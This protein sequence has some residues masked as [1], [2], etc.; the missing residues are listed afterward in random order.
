MCSAVEE[1][2]LEQIQAGL[3]DAKFIEHY[4]QSLAP[5][6][7]YLS[8]LLS[9]AEKAGF[10]SFVPCWVKCR[11]GCDYELYVSGAGAIVHCFTLQFAS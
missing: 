9:I 11:T 5:E 4:C 10:A 7:G 3:L 1:G 2:E 6:L 8:T